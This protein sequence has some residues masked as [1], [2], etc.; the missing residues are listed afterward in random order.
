MHEEAKPLS[1][2]KVEANYTD[3]RWETSWSVPL[4]VL[5]KT[6]VGFGEGWGLNATFIVDFPQ[7]RFLT[8]CPLGSGE[9]D[10]HR[11]EAFLPLHFVSD[12]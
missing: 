5:K 4:D 7:Q 1:Q 2:V 12:G 6:V 11:P 10:F 3:D 9:P 8:A